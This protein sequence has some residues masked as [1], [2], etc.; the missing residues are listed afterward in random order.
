MTL[1]RVRESMI[2]TPKSIACASRKKLFRNINGIV[3]ALATMTNDLGPFLLVRHFHWYMLRF[4]NLD[5]LSG[6][7]SEHQKDGVRKGW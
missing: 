6:S 7:K 5:A 4:Q 1:A 3:P 2:Q